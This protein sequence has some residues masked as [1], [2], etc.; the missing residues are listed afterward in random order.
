M[1][2]MRVAYR[3]PKK[4]LRERDHLEHPGDGSII[5]K[6]IFRTWDGGAWT[7]LIWLRTRT[8]GGLL[9]MR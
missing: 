5:L 7:G 9:Y 1:G 3:V 2:K 6:W 4:N 8:R